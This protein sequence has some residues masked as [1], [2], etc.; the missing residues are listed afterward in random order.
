MDFPPG[1]PK[2][3][4]AIVRMENKDQLSDKDWVGS[5]FSHFVKWAKSIEFTGLPQKSNGINTR[6]ILHVGK[7]CH[8]WGEGAHTG[9]LQDLDLGFQF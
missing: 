1:I 2:W 8:Q 5:W 9:P 3:E 4:G 7:K 6:E